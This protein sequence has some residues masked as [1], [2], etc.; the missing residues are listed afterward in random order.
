MRFHVG[1]IVNK[2]TNSF[3]YFKWMQLDRAARS[4]RFSEN[5]IFYSETKMHLGSVTPWAKSSS[6]FW[7]GSGHLYIF[8]QMA[9]RRGGSVPLTLAFQICNSLECWGRMRI[10]ELQVLTAY[11]TSWLVRIFSIVL[12]SHSGWWKLNGS[13][14]EQPNTH[15]RYGCCLKWQEQETF[16]ELRLCSEGS[17]FR[18]G[19]LGEVF[20]LMKN[21][22]GFHFPFIYCCVSGL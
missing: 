19:S 5:K 20:I 21:L 3:T 8:C 18:V 1:L 11:E 17:A 10:V 13:K 16:D 15:Q 4:P 7:F 14:D 9:V 22:R 2:I 6:V 12:S